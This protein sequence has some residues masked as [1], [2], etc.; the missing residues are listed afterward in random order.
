VVAGGDLPGVTD[1]YGA[2]LTQPAPDPEDPAAVAAHVLAETRILAGGRRPFDEAHM[3][4]LIARDMVRADRYA[5]AGNHA[6]IAGGEAS[7]HDLGE[8]AVPTLVIHGTADPLFPVEHG[9]ALAD[10]I[11]GARLMTLADAGHGLEPADHDAVAR[12]ILA[13]TAP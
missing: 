9:A 12:A 10:A 5:S 6:A 3:R 4:D 11:P 1:E 8:I 13:H 2:F 7:P